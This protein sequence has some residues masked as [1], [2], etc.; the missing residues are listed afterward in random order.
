MRAIVASLIRDIV[1]FIPLIVILPQFMGIEGI[2][3]AAPIADCIAMVVT[4]ILTAT[5]MRT[6]R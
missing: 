5:Y 4:G 3:Y 6:L 2:L 1:C